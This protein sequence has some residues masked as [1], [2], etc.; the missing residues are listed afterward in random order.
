VMHSKGSLR[1]DLVGASALVGVND[2]CG[3]RTS[4]IS[5]DHTLYCMIAQWN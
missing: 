5:G 2:V 4:Q 1:S 3:G